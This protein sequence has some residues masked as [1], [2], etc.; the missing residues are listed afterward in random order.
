MLFTTLSKRQLTTIKERQAV[1]ENEPPACLAVL[2]EFN[3]NLLEKYRRISAHRKSSDIVSPGQNHVQATTDTQHSH[4]R[5]SAPARSSLHYFTNKNAS[6]QRQEQVRKSKCQNISNA[7]TSTEA[8]ENTDHE[9][10][11]E[12]TQPIEGYYYFHVTSKSHVDAHILKRD[13]V[14]QIF[15]R[16]CIHYARVFEI[17]L[18]NYCI[19]DNH[20]HLKIGV[21]AEGI[22]LE[23]ARK[24]CAKAVGCIKQQFTNRFKVWYNIDYRREKGHR[25]PKLGG[26]SMWSGT[27][28]I[29]HIHDDAYL[30]TSALYVEANRIKV[31]CAELIE[32]LDRPPQVTSSCANDCY[33]FTNGYDE[34]FRTL[35]GSKFQ[36][37]Q[38]YMNEDLRANTALTDGLDGIWATPE[39]VDQLWHLPA[40]KL[41]NGLRKVHV[42]KER[43]ILK[44]TPS[45]LRTYHTTPFIKRL[46]QTAAVRQQKFAQLV[47]ASCWKSRHTSGSSECSNNTANTEPG[48]HF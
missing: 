3:R 26:G 15:E 1:I 18:T 36:S 25:I 4:F 48:V 17:A 19:M 47:L 14:K 2:Y 43:R 35:L 32:R 39:E 42:N 5:F 31:T 27:L 16:E 30:A 38:A 44:I 46:G 41:Q 34:L 33:G 37:A 6:P 10:P 8:P 45:N 20:F 21:P 28:H 13:D 11:Q 29:D 22:S 40:C 9:R 12:S 7:S 24:R 23:D